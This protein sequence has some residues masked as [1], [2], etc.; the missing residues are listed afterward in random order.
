MPNS[1][2]L[3]MFPCHTPSVAF[4]GY[5]LDFALLPPLLTLTLALRNTKAEKGLEEEGKLSQNAFMSL[6]ENG[7]LYFH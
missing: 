5:P 2:Q 3:P 6:G 7:S 1:K 4:L